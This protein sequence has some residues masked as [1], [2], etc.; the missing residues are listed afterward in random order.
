MDLPMQAGGLLP[1]A[2]GPFHYLKNVM[3]L[4]QGAQIRLFN[5][6][7]GEFLGTITALG[8]KAGEI[9]LGQRLK[10]QPAPACKIHLLFAPIRKERMDWLVEKAV[11]LGATDLHPVLTQNTDNRKM[12]EERMRLQII[13]AAEQ[14]ERLDLPVLHPAQDFLKALAGWNGNIPLLA[15]IERQ[16]AK[17]LSAALPAQ[18]ELAFLIGPSGGFTQDEKDYLSNLPFVTPVTLGERILR[19]E[20]AAAALLS[21]LLV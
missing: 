14:C 10:D 3:R 19:S 9:E 7:E 16:D 21:A 18:G 12:N 13:E 5:G 2:D 8:K 20:T 17:Q 1:L 11:E 15:A 6:A 4:G